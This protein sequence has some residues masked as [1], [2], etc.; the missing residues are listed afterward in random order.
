MTESDGRKK[1]DFK[2]G[3]IVLYTA[4]EY[5]DY[6][7]NDV[8]VVLED[9]NIDEFLKYIGKNKQKLVVTFLIRNGIV[10]PI[11]YREIWTSNYKNDED[12][13]VF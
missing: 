4:G 13:E 9:F 8:L 10:E 2:K 7:V 5:S 6:E 3:D 12:I 11:H 1:S